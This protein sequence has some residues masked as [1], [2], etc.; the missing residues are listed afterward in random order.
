[1]SQRLDAPVL[2]AALAQPAGP[3]APVDVLAT[4]AS[5]NAD[6]AAAPRAWR[7]VVAAEQE[8][9]R[10]RHERAWSSPPGTSVSLSMTVPM[11]PEPDR[12]GWLPLLTGLAVRDGLSALAA[13]EGRGGAVEFALKWPNDVLLRS[14]ASPD[15]PGA[16]GEFGKVCGILCETV[17]PGLVVA[18]IGVNV[19]LPREALPVPTATSLHLH[20]VGAGAADARERVVIAIA[21]AFARC[22]EAWWAGGAAFAGLAAAYRAACRTIGSDVRV[23]IPVDETVSGVGRDIDEFGR[24]VVDGPGGPA[25]YAAGDVVHVRPGE[26]A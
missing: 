9:G 11:P 20:G 19:A 6:S 18:G 7:L 21:R 8:S 24:L 4:T 1:M 16:P 17:A 22:H 23:H 2:L 25:A 15:S 12:W 14:T 5:T 13:A 10:G 3:W 26:G